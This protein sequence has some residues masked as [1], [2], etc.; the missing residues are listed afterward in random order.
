MFVKPI[1]TTRYLHS[2]SDH[3]RYVKEG[4]ARGQ[5]RRLRRICSENEEYWKYAEKVRRKL[6]SRGYGEHGA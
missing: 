6:V 5:A 2:Q 4:I 1:D 3:P